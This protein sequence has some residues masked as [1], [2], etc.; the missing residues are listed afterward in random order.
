VAVGAPSAEWGEV[1]I[2]FVVP[3][4]PERPPD[5]A[6]LTALVESRLAAY[7]KPREYRFVDSVPRN[8]LGKVE[9]HRLAV[10]GAEPPI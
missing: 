7:K 9:R 1:V 8:A 10:S 4:D 2:A 6:D 3:R 5:A